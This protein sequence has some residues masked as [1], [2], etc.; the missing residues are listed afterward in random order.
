MILLRTALPIAL[1]ALA[2]PALADVSA[3]FQ[4][5]APKDRFT[6]RN[7]GAC[8][9]TS[10]QIVLD[11]SGSKAGLIFDVTSQGA[12]VEV[13]QPLEL[14]AG[15][16]SLTAAPVVRDGDTMVR[17]DVRE[18]APGA[19]IAFTIDVDDTAG[20]REITVSGSEIEA[21]QVSLEQSGQVHTAQFSS[22]ATATVKTDACL[23]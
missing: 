4:E 18:L 8:A 10:A 22:R 16:G 23:S 17:M 15:A 5:G 6:F 7:D 11:L 2:A 12:G 1:L 19:E 20:G 14:V 9:I 21:A 3:T 13:F